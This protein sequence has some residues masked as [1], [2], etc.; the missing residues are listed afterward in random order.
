MR[1][2]AFYFIDEETEPHNCNINL[3]PGYLM[4]ENVYQHKSL[5][6]ISQRSSRCGA[7]ETNPNRNHEVAGSIPGLQLWVKDPVLL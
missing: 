6:N 4:P 2:V 1:K 7:A 5:K 3:S